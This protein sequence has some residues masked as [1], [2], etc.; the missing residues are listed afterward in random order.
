[1][2]INFIIHIYSLNDSSTSIGDIEY[3]QFL[4]STGLALQELAKDKPVMKQVETHTTSFMKTLVDVEK[5]L[6]QHINY[7][8]QVSTG[9]NM[10]NVWNYMYFKLNLSCRL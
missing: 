9:I 3:K 2:H 5:K 10:A 8:T 4:A 7:L 1:M 6:T